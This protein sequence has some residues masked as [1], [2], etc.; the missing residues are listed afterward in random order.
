MTSSIRPWHAAH[1]FFTPW[2]KTQTMLY[3]FVPLLFLPLRSR[4]ALVALPLLAE[5]FFNSRDQLWTTHYHYNAM[6]WIVLVLA[7]VDG[8]AR[9]HVL[10]LA[11][12][13][14][15]ARRPGWSSCRSG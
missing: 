9:L 13:A 1:V 3:L 8:A 14:I 11:A 15:R 6:P 2:V 7:A 5:R 12:V 10:R 4:Y